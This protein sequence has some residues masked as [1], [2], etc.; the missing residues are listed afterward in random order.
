LANKRKPAE[1]RPFLYPK[2]RP[3]G[4]G[5]LSLGYKK[6]TK[7]PMR[8]IVSAKLPITSADLAEADFNE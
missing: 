6:C 8:I 4:Y 1:G 5:E 3:L 7:V 2:R